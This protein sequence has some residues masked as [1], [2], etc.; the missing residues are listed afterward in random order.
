M[1][2]FAGMTFF[3]FFVSR[4]FVIPAKAGIP[5]YSLFLIILPEI[6]CEGAVWVFLWFLFP[7][8]LVYPSLN[9]PSFARP[10]GCPVARFLFRELEQWPFLREKHL[11]LSVT[12][13]AR[14]MR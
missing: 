11:S 13:V 9:K 7:C 10:A 12:C 6:S 4:L 1:P 3:L 5:V 8:I 2:A 14:I